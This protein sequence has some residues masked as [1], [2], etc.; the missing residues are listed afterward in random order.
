MKKFKE[1][2]SAIISIIDIELLAQGYRRRL[3]IMD[4]Q[5]KAL[6]ELEDK[7]REV[8]VEMEKTVTNLQALYQINMRVLNIVNVPTKAGEENET[9]FVSR[10]T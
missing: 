5:I 2:S 7:Y 8:V 9:D 6:R 3:L 10:F 1:L 4:S